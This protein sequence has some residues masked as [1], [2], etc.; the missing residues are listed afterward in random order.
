MAPNCLLPGARVT[1]TEEYC[2]LE[3]VLGRGGSGS[4]DSGLVGLLMK[5][6]S[7]ASGLSLGIS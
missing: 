1:R 3:S 7:K 4:V 5:M 2:F 6:C